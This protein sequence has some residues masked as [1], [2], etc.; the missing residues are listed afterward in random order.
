MGLSGC[1]T[2]LLN[3]KVCTVCTSLGPAM[4]YVGVKEAILECY[5]I[6]RERCC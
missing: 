5:N 6:N 3:G 1:L 4:D 2:L